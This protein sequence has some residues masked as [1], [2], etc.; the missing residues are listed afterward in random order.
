MRRNLIEIGCCE[1]H[2]LELNRGSADFMPKRI[3]WKPVHLPLLRIERQQYVMVICIVS[4]APE[5]SNYQYPPDCA[6]LSI[7]NPLRGKLPSDSGMSGI[8]PLTPYLH[9]AYG[10]CENRSWLLQ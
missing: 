8:D 9:S 7:P 1:L 5:P 10:H 2:Q 4:M 3:E 6:S